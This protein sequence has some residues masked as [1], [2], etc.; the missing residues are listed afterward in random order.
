MFQI[1]NFGV[2]LTTCFFADTIGRRRLFLTSTTGRL[3]A[4]IAWTACSPSYAMDG[5]SAAAKAVIGMIFIYYFLY[6]LA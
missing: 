5:S 3:V 4:F 6:N 1:F 2:A